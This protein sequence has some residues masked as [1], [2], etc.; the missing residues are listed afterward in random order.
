MNKKLFLISCFIIF[1]VKLWEFLTPSLFYYFLNLKYY[2]LDI[3]ILILILISSHITFCFILEK[4]ISNDF[5]NKKILLYALF[6]L[7][8]L[9]FW[10]SKTKM[11]KLKR[12]I[13]LYLPNNNT[14]FISYIN[15][16]CNIIIA[17]LIIIPL[18]ICEKKSLKL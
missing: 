9:I 16:M 7:I 18:A 14:F 13:K 3:L 2:L 11:D 4:G 6:G 5:K 1:P 12:K 15:K 8:A 17:I 10:M